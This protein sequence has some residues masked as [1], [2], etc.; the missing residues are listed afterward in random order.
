MKQAK[1]IAFVDV[2][3]WRAAHIAL[4][5]GASYRT[6]F[7]GNRTRDDIG[8]AAVWIKGRIEGVNLTTGEALTVRQPWLLSS[9]LPPLTVGRGEFTAI[10]DAEWLCF[11]AKLNNGARP[12]L[13]VV[14]GGEAP[15]A[16]HVAYEL[17]PGVALHVK[18]K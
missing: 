5:K 14:L 7:T 16:G 15:P 10:E 2:G 6:L 13:R 3:G 9:D 12:V 4:P 17:A 1:H 8:Y 18:E 11:D